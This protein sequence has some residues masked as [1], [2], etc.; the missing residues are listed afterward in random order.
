M[1]QIKISRLLYIPVINEE[2]LTGEP[3]P[4]QPFSK[5]Y[6]CGSYSCLKP[7]NV[8]DKLCRR[9][10]VQSCEPLVRELGVVSENHHRLSDYIGRY[11]HNN[12]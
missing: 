2:I 1:N 8:A 7:L 6:G 10:H 11:V 9:T 5:F 12:I 4:C 3:K